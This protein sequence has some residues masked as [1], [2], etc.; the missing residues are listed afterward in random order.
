MHRANT[1]YGGIPFC[2]EQ[3]LLA[4]DEIV[5]NI[6]PFES[7]TAC[8][9]VHPEHDILHNVNKTIIIMATHLLVIALQLLDDN[10]HMF[11]RRMAHSESSK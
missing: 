6:G 2:T 7:G 4:D 3:Q 11:L 5:V 9:S 1:Q 8:T 10:S